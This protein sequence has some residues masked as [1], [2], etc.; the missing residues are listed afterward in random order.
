MR[1]KYMWLE[2]SKW[3]KDVKTLVSHISAHQKVTSV[4]EMF[5]NQVNRVICSVEV[6]NFPQSFLLLTDG[7]SNTD[8]YSLR[9]T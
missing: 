8:V 7:F 3:A 1:E 4:K 5:N 2:F 6:S 9:L